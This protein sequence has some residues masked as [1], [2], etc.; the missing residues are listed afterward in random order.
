M[1]EKISIFANYLSNNLLSNKSATSFVLMILT[2]IGLIL[3]NASQ[4]KYLNLI[5]AWI[6]YVAIF[7]IFASKRTRFILI[8][9]I[10]P[11]V[12]ISIFSWIYKIPKPDVY[13][14]YTTISHANSMALYYI[15]GYNIAVFLAI[16][17]ITIL[18]IYNQKHQVHHPK[19]IIISLA[20]IILWIGIE[21]DVAPASLFARTSYLW[22]II[23]TTS[24]PEDLTTKHNF[25]LDGP[26]DFIVFLRTDS[27]RSDYWNE[28]NLSGESLLLAKWKNNIISFPK[29]YSFRANTNTSLGYIFTRYQGN[30]DRHAFAEKSFIH[31][32][33]YL[34]FDTYY[35]NVNDQEIGTPQTN[36]AALFSLE[37]KVVSNN[38]NTSRDDRSF[39]HLKTGVGERGMDSI[40]HIQ[41]LN[42]MNEGKITKPALI[43]ISH[44]CGG[45]I[46]WDY[47]PEDDEFTHNKPYCKA[48]AGKYSHCSDAEIVNAYKNSLLYTDYLTNSVME[49]LK[50]YNSLI[51]GTSDHGQA[52][53][54]Y[55][56][57]GH[58]ISVELGQRSDIKYKNLFNVA[59]FVWA[60]D[61]YI[62][63]NKEKWNNINNN[64]KNLMDHSFIFH[65]ILDCAGV[66]GDLVEKEKSFCATAKPVNIYQDTM[67]R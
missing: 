66:S 41:F 10:L 24:N 61:A 43:I 49:T 14:L 60:S 39:S 19:K 17:L 21:K 5:G 40:P 30:Q 36:P 44:C 4:K 59:T 3:N 26:P 58:G 52:L 56:N 18:A 67:Q 28:M 16:T 54:E 27:I 63:K 12:I 55:G 62:A 9:I 15:D 34:N 29:I 46:A 42:L 57:Y 13:T 37:A 6:F 22:E 47:Y 48:K 51:I 50:D 32:F 38:K 2:N 25:K 65:S 7:T 11:I 53:G 64:S 1:F 23:T 8:S 31:I 20:F 35:L 33:N 45:H